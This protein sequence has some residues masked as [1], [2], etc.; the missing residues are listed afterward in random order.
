MLEKHELIYAQE[1]LKN[2][3]MILRSLIDKINKI[4]ANP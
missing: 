2:N 4:L 1:N 3:L